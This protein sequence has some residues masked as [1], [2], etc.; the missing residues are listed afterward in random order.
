M[1]AIGCDAI[2]DDRGVTKDTSEKLRILG[3][4]AVEL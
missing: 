4:E 3:I 1:P 2:N